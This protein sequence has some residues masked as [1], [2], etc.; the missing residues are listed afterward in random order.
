MVSEDLLIVTVVI[1]RIMWNNGTMEIKVVS[2]QIPVIIPVN[3]NN[4][5][6]QH[7]QAYIA[8]FMIR[9]ALIT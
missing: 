4:T 7:G 1:Q 8:E 5:K 6:K 9:I 3:K 2:V